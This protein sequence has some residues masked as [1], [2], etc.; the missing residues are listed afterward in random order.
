MRNPI[1]TTDNRTPARTA[2]P[3][4]RTAR[5]ALCHSVAAVM[6]QATHT[7][8]FV[9]SGFGSLPGGGPAPSLQPIG[10]GAL[11]I[12]DEAQNLPL[13]T[14]EQIRILSNLETD[15]EKLL[16][17]IL[18]GQLNLVPLLRSR[19][20]KSLELCTL[21]HKRI[22]REL[23]LDHLHPARLGAGAVAGG[24]GR[25]GAHARRRGDT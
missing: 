23:V 9:C 3:N 6:D 22:A 13:Q 12:I 7:S 10:A 17:I 1:P 5:I 2:T 25:R 21:L 16:Q 11:L 14:L 4:T 19:G 18:V 24:D 20:P 15:K 8:S